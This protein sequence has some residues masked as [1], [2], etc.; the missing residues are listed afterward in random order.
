MRSARASPRRKRRRIEAKGPRTPCPP[1]P[2]RRERLPVCRRPPRRSSGCA[3]ESP[4]TSRGSGFSTTTCTSGAPCWAPAAAAAPPSVR[5]RLLGLAGSGGNGCGA[6]AGYRHSPSPYT[7]ASRAA[8][9]GSRR[10]SFSRVL[11]PLVTSAG[12]EAE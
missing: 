8:K 2:P 10:F 5:C 11:M 4:P 12:Q 3:M 1:P 6:V 7:A 9:G